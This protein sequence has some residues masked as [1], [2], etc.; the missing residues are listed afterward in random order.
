MKLGR[1]NLL[2]SILLAGIMMLFLIGYF[3]YMLPSLYVNYLM[4]Q[5]LRSIREQH[6]SYMENGTYEG[7]SVRSPSACFSVEIPKQGESI[8]ITGK[9]FSAEITAKDETLKQLFESG[10]ELI[11]SYESTEKDVEG[12]NKELKNIEQEMG[13]WMEDMMSLLKEKADL[14]VAIDILYLQD[15][16]SEYKNENMKVHVFSDTMLV[17]EASAEDSV[18]QYT[19]YVA[20]ES[21]E[22]SFVIS[23]LPVM[24][25]DMNEIRPVVFS[26]LPM[27]GAVIILLVLL[28]SQVYS[29]GI[30]S[31]IVQLVHHTEHMKDADDFD[32]APLSASRH[33]KRREDEVGELSRTMDELYEQIKESYQI[34]EEK[35]EALEEENKRQ[36]VFLRASSHQLKTPISA[37][38]LLVD[39]MINEIGKYKERDVYL[40]KVKEQLLSMR[41]MVEDILYLNHCSEHIRM[42]QI[43][44]RKLLEKK[45]CSYQVAIVD[46]RLLVEINGLSAMQINTDEMMISQIIDNILSNAVKYTPV[47]EKIEILVKDKEIQIRNNGVKIKEDIL[48]HV[49]DPF[50]SGDQGTGNHGLGLYIASYYAKKIGV[51]IFVCNGENSVVTKIGFQENE[52]ITS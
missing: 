39:G 47:G 34:L 8:F 11:R 15:A 12:K 33:W 37:A 45:L 32:V 5:N 29:K 9:S 49:F 31:P 52:V 13:A 23:M 27:L 21:T 44:V 16:G 10:K 40:P 19:N 20:V 14:P 48:P 46:K 22:D 3:I 4:E 30:V 2:Y 51:E 50:V 38:L 41:K 6:N 35:N 1:K 28:F 43:E 25:P 7:V 42:E 17:I 36:E 24:T 18:N 26:S